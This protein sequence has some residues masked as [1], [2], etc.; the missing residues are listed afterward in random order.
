MP[1]STLS[2]RESCLFALFAMLALGAVFGPSVRA[3]GLAGSA[4]A[5]NPPWRSFPDAMDV[6]SNI[7]LAAIGVWGLRWLDWLDRAHDS[8][9]DAA[10]LPQAVAAAPVDA[11]DC[12]WMF[13]AGLLL[14]AAASAFYHL[15]PD[16]V[17][18]AA[19]RAAMAVAIA[20]L[21]GFAVS[22][23]VSARAGW[24]AAWFTLAGGLLAAVAGYRTGNALPW[25]L[26]Q[27]GGMALMLALALA[28]PVG[29]AIGLK[30]GWVIFFF[31][32]A[33]LFELSD[34]AIYQATHHLLSGFSLKHLAVAL[35]TLPVLHALQDVGRQ[36]VRHNPG[37][38]LTA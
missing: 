30:L 37:A 34:P 18:L 1:L 4:F 5:Y 12:A 10:P 38:A 21:V 15:Q 32:L 19:D 2:R 24:P 13:F 29:G 23:R 17:R 31:V 20:G 11:L 36:T 27:F 28:R 6:L 7:P 35:A 33:K 22:E 16:G 25:A 9:Q 8:V 3:A 14:T 26:V